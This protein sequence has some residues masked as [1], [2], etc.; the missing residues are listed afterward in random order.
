MYFQG[1]VK[2]HLNKKKLKLN[3][4]K[5]IRTF[6]LIAF[7]TAIVGLE[8]VGAQYPRGPLQRVKIDKVSDEAAFALR[9]RIIVVAEFGAIVVRMNVLIAVAVLLLRMMR[10]SFASHILTICGRLANIEPTFV[11]EYVYGE[12]GLA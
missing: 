7:A 6:Q 9:I 8:T 1:I 5:K 12:H 3:K 2:L 10:S 11:L 4:R